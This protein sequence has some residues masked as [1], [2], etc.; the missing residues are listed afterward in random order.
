MNTKIIKAVE[1]IRDGK[2]VNKLSTLTNKILASA[3]HCAG[4]CK[5]IQGLRQINSDNKGI[6]ALIRKYG[7]IIGNDLPIT[8]YESDAVVISSLFDD[9]QNKKIL[10][11]AYGLLSD[12]T[13]DEKLTIEGLLAGYTAILSDLKEVKTRIDDIQEAF[14]GRYKRLQAEYGEKLAAEAAEKKSKKKE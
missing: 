4:V 7:D 14:Q 9:I 8:D 3:Y 5:T 10:F 6:N 11:E 13:G 2:R 1:M 12:K